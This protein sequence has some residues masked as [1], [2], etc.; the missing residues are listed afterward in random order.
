MGKFLP[1]LS[2]FAVLALMVLP[3][4]NCAEPDEE[5]GTRGNPSC[6]TA[7]CVDDSVEFLGLQIN[8]PSPILI[9]PDVSLFTV[10]GE[11]FAADFPD[12]IITWVIFNSSGQAV[13]NSQT[14]GGLGF[15]A[16]CLNRSFVLQVAVPCPNGSGI[17]AGINQNYTLNVTLF[18]IDQDGS[19]HE[20]TGEH[21]QSV[22]LSPPG[23]TN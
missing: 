10:E 5:L 13:L 4:N 7:N 11:C 23:S 9:G 15:T 3:F 12:N 14:A 17:C 21:S 2:L 19:A 20:G 6:V 16:R 18:G 8:N 1:Q 22:T